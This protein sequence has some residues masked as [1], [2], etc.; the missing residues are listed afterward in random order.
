MLT[1]WVSL[2]FPVLVLTESS[3]EI[4]TILAPR[5]ITLRLCPWVF[6]SSDFLS[7]CSQFV[8]AYLWS[9]IQQLASVFSNWALY[10]WVDSILAKLSWSFSNTKVGTPASSSF[11]FIQKK[12]D[13]PADRPHMNL[14]CEVFSALEMPIYQ[15]SEMWLFCYNEQLLDHFIILVQM[16]GLPFDINTLPWF[17]K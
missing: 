6:L 2:L 17:W 16:A 7:P 14:C 1:V 15:C 12:R 10:W 8:L 13:C 9:V 5:V 11:S 4:V 3:F